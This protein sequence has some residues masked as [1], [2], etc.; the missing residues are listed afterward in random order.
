MKKFKL[1]IGDD[2]MDL[3]PSMLTALLL[4]AGVITLIIKN[5]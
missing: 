3:L 4:L 2:L 1:M 5:L